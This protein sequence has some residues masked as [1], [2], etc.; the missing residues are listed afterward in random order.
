MKKVLQSLMLLLGALVLP[1][2]AYAQ[3]PTTYGD[4]NG[5]GAV[6]I[7]DVN[8]VINMI[9][10][11]AFD[12]GGDVNGDG[13][14]N[15][16]DVNAVINIIL[17]GEAPITDEHEY[18]DLGLPSGTLWATCNIGANSPEEYGDYFAWGEIEP[19]DYYDWSNYKWCEGTSNTITKYCSNS[20]YGTF[21]GKR[22]MEL[23]DDAACMNWGPA[24]CIPSMYQLRELCSWSTWEKTSRN[25]V[26]GFVLTGPNGNSLFLPAAGSYSFDVYD[27]GFAAEYWS[28]TLSTDA[29]S[30]AYYLY[31]TSGY[32]NN[33]V[34][35]I[36]SRAKGY[37]VRAIRVRTADTYSLYIDPQRLD[38]GAVYTGDTCTSKLTIINYTKA[39]KTVTATTTGPFSFKL[40]EGSATSMT[41]EVPGNSIASVTVMFT[42][43]AS[44]DFNGNVTFQSPGF[45]GGQSV[46]PIRALS[47]SQAELGQE[48]VD[49]GLPS[50]T[51]WATR[52]IGADSPEQ[53]GDYFAWGEIEPKDCYDYGTYKWCDG[54]YLSLTKY[55]TDTLYG[56]VDNKTEL[57]PE[58]DAAWMNWGPM[59]RM[60]TFDQIME[61]H[62]YCSSRWVTLNDVNGCF[63]TG[64][65]GNSMFL[66]AAG[67]LTDN[68]SES[69]NLF[70]EYWSRTLVYAT[71][72]D[73]PIY[74]YNMTL[75]SSGVGANHM[76]R[77]EGYSIRAVRASLNDV[78]IDQ[79]SLDLGIGLIGEVSTGELTI[80][81][82][83][84]EAIT[85]TASV[86]EP[87]SFKRGD[88]N[89]SSL[90]VEVP[91]DSCTRVT[92]MLTA[93][94]PG[95]Y[96]GNVVF[97]HPGFSG[98]QSVIPVHARAYADSEQDYVDLGLPSGTLWATRN[99]GANSPEERGDKFAWGETAPKERYFWENYKWGDAY[100]G[101]LTKYC[102]NS[103]YG[104]ADGKKELEPEDDA[105]WVNW[106]PAWRMPTMRQLSELRDKCS[107][108][109]ITRNG[110]KGYLV[111]GP[112]GNTM[113]LP[114]LGSSYHNSYDYYWSRTLG[115]SDDPSEAV[116]LEVSS[117]WVMGSGASRSW[118][119][120]V[121]PVCMS[122][123]AVY[124][125]QQSLDFIASV[126]NT[127]TG[128][129][130]IVNCTNFPITL[131]GS[132]DEPLSFKWRGNA[133][134]NITV[135]V[136]GKRYVQIAVL[137]TATTPG[138]YNGKLTFRSAM[139]GS[140]IE[141][142]VS[143]LVFPDAAP[144]QDAVDLGLPSGTLWA[145]CNVGANCPE[146]LGDRFAWGETVTKDY[147]DWSNYKLCEGNYNS[148]TKY[149]TNSAYGVVDNLTE[150]EPEDDAAWVNWGPKW[151]IP[152]NEQFTELEENCVWK[153]A[154]KDGVE[155]RL[156]TG[157]NGNSIFIPATERYDY[158]SR[159]LNAGIPF[160]AY[161]RSF[162]QED[163]VWWLMWAPRNCAYFVR[164]VC[165]PQ[166]ERF[167]S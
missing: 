117:Q 143:A 17:G 156:V 67:Y 114:S 102:T 80:V 70:G 140:L 105:A 32:Y 29:S 97:K 152:S 92:V 6:N 108:T 130:T 35:Y 89:A 38:M 141:V 69:T 1:A 45:D 2:A 41:V 120:A 47:V 66:P 73:G 27:Q 49:L 36:G 19:K 78:Y 48:Y 134:S 128:I 33:M 142:P 62:D 127:C 71:N 136:P 87:F 148:L 59:W 40:G 145:S 76:F 166:D 115:S 163:A 16:S 129:L 160:Y 46:I 118:G 139:D 125:E 109:W 103:E 68:L 83:T 153:W 162:S 147:Y 28:C 5:D 31:N 119:C 57:E 3:Q 42:A 26:T 131:T 56:T 151:R 113:F 155:G 11:S 74:S 4:V 61:L 8:S 123:D 60:P 104:W 110:T 86:C 121:R 22:V 122:H 88:G 157:P 106:G 126:G 159:T 165:V 96:D 138:Q 91:G 146:E 43:T 164:A 55:C 116:A 10:T 98:G 111:T 21:D 77:N 12:S 93:S 90:T 9:L 63:V 72:P 30:G 75:S 135:D 154:E 158:W 44:G 13:T 25:G 82:C 161:G 132:A 52:N 64:P 95:E 37:P 107:W 167:S 100:E 144:Q 50:G 84:K 7:T 24:W 23:E 54:N 14:V 39:P 34:Q 85:L 79:Q 65:N 101:M 137:F 51:L 99:V 124:V 15:I 133:T 20:D 150:L 58:D 112:N 94:A 149:C 81:N 18:V 53:F